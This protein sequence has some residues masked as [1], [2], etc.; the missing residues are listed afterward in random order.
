MPMNGRSDSGRIM[1]QCHLK[2]SNNQFVLQQSPGGI[3]KKIH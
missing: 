1:K 2:C 3:I